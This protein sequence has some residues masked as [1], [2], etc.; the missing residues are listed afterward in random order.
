[1][2]V[3]EQK[4][5]EVMR[6]GIRCKVKDVIKEILWEFLGREASV[7]NSSIKRRRIAVKLWY[8]RTDRCSFRRS[9]GST[10]YTAAVFAISA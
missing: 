10:Q 6:L 8:T 1:M 2:T 5:P 9:V 3:G 4:V 7:T